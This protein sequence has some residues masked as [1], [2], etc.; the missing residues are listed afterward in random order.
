MI[1]IVVLLKDGDLSI[2]RGFQLRDSCLQSVHL[3]R[4]VVRG[5]RVQEKK[6]VM[7]RARASGANTR[8]ARKS[9]ASPTTICSFDLQA[10]RMSGRLRCDSRGPEAPH[11]RRS[12][13]MRRLHAVVAKVAD[14]ASPRGI[15]T[16]VPRPFH[17]CIPLDSGC[18]FVLIRAGLIIASEVI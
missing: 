12:L 7:S 11:V 18:G 6:V 1:R 8:V 10:R 9:T 15:E 13:L 3:C 17:G 4:Q 5:T 14:A 2:D 16:A